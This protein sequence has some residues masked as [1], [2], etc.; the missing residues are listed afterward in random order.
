MVGMKQRSAQL[1]HKAKEQ[2]ALAGIDEKQARS[3]RG[4]QLTDNDY[5]LTLR[6]LAERARTLGLATT[7]W[8]SATDLAREHQVSRS[9]VA[10]AMRR[11]VELCLVEEMVITI[12]NS[13]R[14]RSDPALRSSQRASENSRIYRSRPRE[15]EHRRVTDLPSWLAPQA[16]VQ[17]GIAR[18][19]KG[20]ASMTRWL[21]EDDEKELAPPREKKPAAA[22]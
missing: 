18:M 6:R 11:L 3:I 16:V 5:L 17:I 8:M 21:V 4:R 12:Q 7:G 2:R 22:V 10:F 14:P 15:G 13:A 19:V 9:V 1:K 20:T